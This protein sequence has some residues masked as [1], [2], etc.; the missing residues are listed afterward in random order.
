MVANENCQE[1]APLRSLDVVLASTATWRSDILTQVGIDHRC[2]DPAYVE[3]TSYQG[4]I[5]EFVKETALNKARSIQHRFK[6]SVIIAADQL[7]HI[8]GETL[9]KPGNKEK[10]IVQLTQ[11]SGKRHQLICAVAVILNGKEE[12]RVEKA[13]LKMRILT[14]KE[15]T[16]YVEIDNP[17]FC[18]GSYKIE[19]LGASLFEH[20]E[21]SDPT[22]I[23]GLPA[24]LL[25]D[26]LR[27]FGYSNLL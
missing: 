18:A 15:I 9:Y 26:I 27:Q 17:V 22:A 23:V 20:I 5:V 13:T 2:I 25:I 14:E 16:N 12:C 3:P 4:E 11:L 7:I 21:V 6:N 1:L 19:S 10:A 24:N 8:D